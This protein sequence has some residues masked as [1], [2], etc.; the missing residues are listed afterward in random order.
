MRGGYHCYPSYTDEE[1][2]T[3]LCGGLPQDLT[4]GEWPGQDSDLDSLM[5]KL[6][7]SLLRSPLRK[8]SLSNAR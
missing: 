7:T 4:A 2:Q 6:S 8:P 5:L 1:S 3:E